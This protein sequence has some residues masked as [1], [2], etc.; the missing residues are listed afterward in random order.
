[1]TLRCCVDSSNS[2]YRH[3][4]FSR[5]GLAGHVERG[6]HPELRGCRSGFLV[7]S[8]KGSLFITADA[9]MSVELRHWTR[10]RSHRG[11]SGRVSWFPERPQR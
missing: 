8:S 10:D 11:R 2:P 4:P 7:C 3:R 6:G 9:R 1:M 5:T